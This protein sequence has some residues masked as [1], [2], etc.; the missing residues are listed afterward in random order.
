MKELA[1]RLRKSDSQIKSLSL[2]NAK[3]RVASTLIQLADKTDRI[4]PEAMEIAQLPTQQDLANMA[5]TS[6][7]TI[8]RSLKTF[9]DAGYIQRKHRYVLITDY[10]RFSDRYI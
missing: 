10:R 8:S 5:G 9:A 2:L 6:R 1:S 4:S 3:G 7:E